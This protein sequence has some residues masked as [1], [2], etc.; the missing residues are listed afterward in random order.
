[1]YHFGTLWGRILLWADRHSSSDQHPLHLDFLQAVQRIQRVHV[2]SLQTVQLLSL[3]LFIH[4]GRLSNPRHHS[5]VG[6]QPFL[7][8]VEAVVSL[9]I[10][11][12]VVVVLPSNQTENTVTPKG[13]KVV[14]CPATQRDNVSC[15]TC[16]L[17]Q[18]QRS[19]IVGFPAHGS[20]HRV[21]NLRLAA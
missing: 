8:S 19:T 17:C 2:A 9:I 3:Q 4:L 1:M 16:Q 6:I 7:Y 13:R 20:R 15:A 12:P 14:V 18:R 21:I 5:D 10:A 11:G